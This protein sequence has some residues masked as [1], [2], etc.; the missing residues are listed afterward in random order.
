MFR[1]LH[2][3]P[4]DRTP[5]FTSQQQ[6]R[7]VADMVSA[8]CCFRLWWT[9][10]MCFTA[11]L[12]GLEGFMHILLHRCTR[13]QINGASLT[14]KLKVQQRGRWSDM[15]ALR[16]SVCPRA[17]LI[18]TSCALHWDYWTLQIEISGRKGAE[19][20]QGKGR[21]NASFFTVNYCE[22]DLC[23]TTS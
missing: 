14:W 2:V 3:K 18:S 4:G 11:R 16:L 6:L 22:A 12:W 5:R 10:E 15:A 19:G 1:L 20:R 7:V 9:G 21:E 8:C 23:S 13:D 17:D